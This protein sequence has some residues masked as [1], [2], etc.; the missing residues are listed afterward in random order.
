M[1]I[2]EG[3]YLPSF[4]S[5]NHQY[6][7]LSVTILVIVF[8]FPMLLFVLCFEILSVCTPR[9]DGVRETPS[10][11]DDIEFGFMPEVRL[12]LRIVI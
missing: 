8:Y 6:F 12:V 2:N 10:F 4:S 7:P 9:K 5:A 11:L 1:A 3:P